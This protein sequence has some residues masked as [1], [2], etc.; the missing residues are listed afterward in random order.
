MKK[1][2][3]LGVA[4]M[5]IGILLALPGPEDV[6]TAGVSLPFTAIAGAALFYDGMKRI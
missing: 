6:A 1:N 2:L 4:E 5:G 3:L